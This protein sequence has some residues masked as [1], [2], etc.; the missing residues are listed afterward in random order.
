LPKLKLSSTTNQSQLKN[1][2]MMKQES[3]LNKELLNSKRESQSINN[4]LSSNLKSP[5]KAKLSKMTSET[6]EKNYNP[7]NRVLKT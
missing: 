6:T 1:I 5:K 3:L 2:L 7:S 4:K